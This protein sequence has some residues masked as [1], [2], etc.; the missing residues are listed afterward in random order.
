MP[1]QPDP[2]PAAADD[3]AGIT[4]GT[5]PLAELAPHPRN[6]R[7][8]LGDLAD[9][10][11]SIAAQGVFEPLVVLTAAAFVAAAEAD[12]N[13]ERPGR[14]ITHVLVMGHRRAAAAAAAGL[15]A[16]PVVVRDDLA[17]AP[18]LAAMIAE[19]LH[20]EA[21]SPLA[22][23]EAM[24]ELARRKWGQRR[25]AAEIGCSQAHVSK[26]MSLL[27]LPEA[28]RAALAAGKLTVADALELH[29]LTGSGDAPSEVVDHVI[30]AAVAAVERGHYVP[31]VLEEAKRD[32]RRAVTELRTREK[33]AREGIEIIAEQRR[34]RMGWPRVY[35]ER[36]P[37]AKAKCLAAV[38]EWSG[39]AGYVCTNP[40]S[41]PNTVLP[42]GRARAR[43]NED[44]REG[45]KAAKARDKACAAIVAGP[46]P[47]TREMI[48][49]LAATLLGSGSGHTDCLRLACR[50]LADAGI[51]PPGADHYKWRDT[52]TAAG[53]RATLLRYARAYALAGDELRVRSRWNTWGEHHAAH[54]AR[55]AGAGGYQPTAWERARLAEAQ[56]CTNARDTLT[57][58]LCG[59]THHDAQASGR[60][61]GVRFDRDHG[62][63]V[64][65]CAWDCTQHRAVR[66]RER[67]SNAPSA[68]AA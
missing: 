8:D 55:L 56:A 46:M 12:G 25:I 23:A 64:Y 21:L 6:P 2:P 65:D 42:G 54:L 57:C 22:E 63:P 51:A 43:E 44:E 34:D 29:K 13:P 39:E 3:S 11:A 24:A 38:I 49:L 41:H 16:V 52:L 50:W 4:P 47:H 18:A 31:Q 59:C 9:L 19:N 30:A 32:L 33:L 7:Q 68:D 45:R 26:R 28:A 48:G 17:G 10:T 35:G 36:A 1:K 27:Q 58:A 53:D 66:E 37:H 15:D 14:G 20:R 61:C 67:D 62:Q 60:G 5:L 40:A